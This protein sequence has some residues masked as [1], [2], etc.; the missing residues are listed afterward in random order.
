MG[1]IYYLQERY[2]F[3]EHHIKKAIAINKSSSLMYSQLGMVCG[4]VTS[5]DITWYSQV[6]CATEAYDEALRC[7]D[8][9]VKLDPSKVLPRFDRTRVLQKA[10]R[11]Q[12]STNYLSGSFQHV[13]SCDTQ[14]A[15]TE[16]E[17]L[18]RRVP[19][20]AQIYLQMGKVNTTH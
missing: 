4:H 16:L 20:E 15:L 9:A 2:Q 14:E 5:P 6:Q 8:K 19:K 3:A 12:V 17:E 10:G 7:L 11:L 13:R 1:V 18:A